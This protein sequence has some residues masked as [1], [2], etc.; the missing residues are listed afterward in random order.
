MNNNLAVLAALTRIRIMV[1]YLNEEVDRN[2]MA[3]ETKI[4]LYVETFLKMDHQTGDTDPVT[5]QQ[6]NR[7]FKLEAAWI[8][9]NLCLDSVDSL[10]IMFGEGNQIMGFIEQ[11][12]TNH[13]DEK[14]MEFALMTVQNTAG[15]LPF[16][17]KLVKET[18]IIDLIVKLIHSKCQ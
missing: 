12:L 9:C 6:W 11:M 18:R 7:F 1:D 3:N 15:F 5:G 17:R 14:L 2:R 10:N 16:A 4:I 8:L 13:K